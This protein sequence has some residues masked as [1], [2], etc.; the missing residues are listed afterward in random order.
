[1]VA[2][3][4]IGLGVLLA[5]PGTSSQ[6][7]AEAPGPTDGGWNVPAMQ[8]L[9]LPYHQASF[10]HLGRELTRFHFGPDLKRPFLYPLIGPPG[11]PYTRMGH[12]HDPVGH[13]HHCSV[14][15]AHADVGGLSFWDD[16]SEGRIVCRAVQEYRD[17]QDSAT[18]ACR[19][20]WQDAAGRAVMRETR[21]LTA[22]APD[23]Q[24]W[25][26]TIAVQLEAPGDQPVTLGPTPFGL[27]G[28]RVAATIGVSDGGGR[29]LDSEG[30]RNEA[31]IFR[32][33]ARW[34]DYSG[35]VAR[36]AAGGVALL[37]HPSNPRHPAAFHVRDDGWMCPSLTLS[38]PMVIEP[39]S[40]LRLCYRLW[41]HAGAP[42][43][44]GIEPHWAAFAG[45][46]AWPVASRP[47]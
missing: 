22:H 28:V 8:V 36:G 11:V 30:R 19:L 38:G 15:I 6:A 13:G 34:V 17:G 35:P 4:M 23:P 33:P 24:G 7:S 43:G 26:L 46:P 5:S 42:D 25:S 39:G 20:D 18:L 12:P 10:Q 9:P 44:S 14:W 2:A 29:V 32:R 21:R 3:T 37:D 45:R 41:I 47:S 40:P 16:R 1:M 31:G 27:L